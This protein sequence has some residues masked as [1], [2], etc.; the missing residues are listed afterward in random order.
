MDRLALGKDKPDY[1]GQEKL[2]QPKGIE[3]REMLRLLQ[4]NRMQGNTLKVIKYI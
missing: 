4:K 1:Y 2:N 3:P